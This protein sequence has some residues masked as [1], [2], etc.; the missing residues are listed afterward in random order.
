MC[1]ICSKVGS[2]LCFLWDMKDILV[3]YNSFHEDTIASAQI[4]CTCSYPAEFLSE[5]WLHK[6]KTQRCMLRLLH[7]SPLL[8]VF[9]GGP[10]QQ[11]VFPFP[12]HS[13][14]GC[15]FLLL[16]VNN[17]APLALVL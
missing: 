13:D 12:T 10:S 7:T 16:T 14:F 17:E 2:L 15:R 9:L 11:R 8:Q 4:I 6:H 1:G 5:H 3:G